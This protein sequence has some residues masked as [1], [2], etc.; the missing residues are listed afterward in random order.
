MTELP[1]ICSNAVEPDPPGRPRVGQVN[2]RALNIPIARVSKK[3]HDNQ[4]PLFYL[5]FVLL[6]FIAHVVRA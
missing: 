4:D 3:I 2:Y 1:P 5:K 6:H